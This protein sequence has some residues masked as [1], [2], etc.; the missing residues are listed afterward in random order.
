MSHRKLQQIPQQIK[1]RNTFITQHL[2]FG[3]E[4]SL[5][6]LAYYISSPGMQ[7]TSAVKIKSLFQAR[8]HVCVYLCVW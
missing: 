4:V 7:N 3:M 1:Q 8:K 5:I 6:I 2:Y